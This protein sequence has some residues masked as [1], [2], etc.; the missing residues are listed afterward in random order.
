MKK[1]EEEVQHVVYM[2]F[3]AILL[4][5]SLLL[6]YNLMADVNVKADLQ[7]LVV[8]QDLLIS[9]IMNADILVYDQS[10]L[11]SSS[12]S[13]VKS[14][15]VVF[16][17]NRKL[18]PM[19][20]NLL[21]E[22]TS[23]FDEEIPY[24]EMDD[25]KG[26]NLRISALFKQVN[27]DD[28]VVYAEFPWLLFYEEGCYVYK[29]DSGYYQQDAHQKYLS[30][31]KINGALDKV[32]TYEEFKDEYR[33]LLEGVGDEVP[34]EDPERPYKTRY[35]SYLFSI[36]KIYDMTEE[37]NVFDW[38]DSIGCEIDYSSGPIMDTNLS[39]C[40]DDDSLF[41]YVTGRRI[42]SVGL[43]NFTHWVGVNQDKVSTLAEAPQSTRYVEYLYQVAKISDLTNA[44][45]KF[46]WANSVSGCSVRLT[47]TGA[48]MDA[49]IYSCRTTLY[50]Y[51]SN[52]PNVE[53]YTKNSIVLL[54]ISDKGWEMY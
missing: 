14:F 32:L 45:N 34:S 47:G 49:D 33:N 30:T 46:A 35:S 44:E 11:D 1:A 8:R 12:N 16:D 4:T 21:N 31:I 48:E 42:I 27:V 26:Y 52:T 53:D 41:D 36:A 13:D 20:E 28:K 43:L 19:S 54:C 15:P 5:L 7:D 9:K 17:Y 6:I 2:V 24:V 29:V 51:L 25:A 40:V 18:L 23:D 22:D 38:A 3:A 50:N 37:G 39:A 10:F